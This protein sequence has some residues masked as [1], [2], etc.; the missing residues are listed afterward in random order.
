METGIYLRHRDNRYRV[1]LHRKGKAIFLG[2]FDTVEE[3]REART[4]QAALSLPTEKYTREKIGKTYGTL[5][6]VDRIIPTEK[7]GNTRPKW[8]CVCRC[9]HK[10][11]VGSSVLERQVSS[12]GCP[13][14]IKTTIDPLRKYFAGKKYGKLLILEV[15]R[16]PSRFSC[17]C[18]CGRVEVVRCGTFSRRAKL[19]CLVCRECNKKLKLERFLKTYGVVGKRISPLVVVIGKGESPKTLVCQCDCGTVFTMRDTSARCAR[20]SCGCRRK[21]LSPEE[22]HLAHILYLTGQ[23]S[24]TSL[25]QRFRVNRTSMHNILKEKLAA[26]K[27]QDP[28]KA[29]LKESN[30]LETWDEL[31]KLYPT[32]TDWLIQNK[33]D[34]KTALGS[35]SSL[36]AEDRLIRAPN[37][38][39][40]QLDS[41]SGRLENPNNAK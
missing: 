15:L 16:S 2:Y 23:F 14:C 37:R 22:A 5:T 11:I 35:I 34:L 8:L 18:D 13:A 19:D 40:L 26:C 10:R 38:I 3:A 24:I 4:K 30:W 21:L 39:H 41:N 7:V 6:V 1:I 36:A 17:Q 12:R 28:R 20:T 25:A 33:S 9:G 31:L 27:Q 32:A 29:L